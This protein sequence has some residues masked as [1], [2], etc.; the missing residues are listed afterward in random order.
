M[1]E[2]KPLNFDFLDESPKKSDEKVTVPVAASEPI[3]GTTFFQYFKEC[4]TNFSEFAKQNLVTAKP[5]YLLV[6]VW[7]LGI[8]N[9]ADQLT[10]SNSSDWAELWI[11]AIFGGIFSGVFAYYISGWF[12]H[13]RVKW[14][15]GTGTIGTSRNIYIFSSLPIAIVGIG[16]KFFNHVAYG[17][18][19]F[20]TYYSDASDIDVIFSLLYLAAI[21]YS[22]YISYRAT[23]VVMRVEKKRAIG[24]FIVAPTLFYIL[25]FV[26]AIL[27]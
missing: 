15:K 11:I 22:I 19:Y 18:D 20:A 8:G 16:L 17:S 2:K 26:V 3:H 4:L 12:Y 14:S 7:V 1:N 9:A 23:R 10:S 24:W 21:I 13:V 6:A 5:K 27:G 25:V